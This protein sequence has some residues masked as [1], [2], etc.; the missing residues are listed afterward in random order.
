MCSDL[1][2]LTWLWYRAWSS[3]YLQPKEIIR[4]KYPLR[5]MLIFHFMMIS[6]HKESN[7]IAQSCLEMY[8]ALVSI[9]SA[10]VIH[11]KVKFKKVKTSPI[12]CN[13]PLSIYIYTH[14]YICFCSFFPPEL[15]FLKMRQLNR[16]WSIFLGGLIYIQKLCPLQKGIRSQKILLH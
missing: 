5:S 3:L 11:F 16:F 10:F 2:H 6:S 13:R 4:A 14:T 15:T 12:L 9:S 1:L 8:F 7:S